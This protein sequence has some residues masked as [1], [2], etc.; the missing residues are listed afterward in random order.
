MTEIKKNQK[1]TK[2][3]ETIPKKASWI[4]SKNPSTDR[5]VNAPDVKL[6][7][8]PEFLQGDQDNRLKFN[9]GATGS[10][11]QPRMHTIIL[12]EIQRNIAEDY[13]ER[14][15]NDQSSFDTVIESAILRATSEFTSAFQYYSYRKNNDHTSHRGNAILSLPASKSCNTTN[16][17]LVGLSSKNL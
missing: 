6:D 8:P 2:A 5:N 14:G 4:P 12:K 9:E 15:R 7:I 11:K 16:T 13:Q 10:S 3:L 17:I 1:Y